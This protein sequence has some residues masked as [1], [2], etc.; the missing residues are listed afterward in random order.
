MPRPLRVLMTTDTLGGVF[1]YS[2]TLCRA[3]RARGVEVMLVTEGARLQ[4]DQKREL[5][6]IAG[7]VVCESSLS[8]EWMDEPWED[9]DRAGGVLL[10][11]ERDFAPDVVHVNGYAH[12]ALPFRAPALIVAHS[13]VPSWWRAV[14]GADA[15]GR[16]AEY[17]RRA[18]AAFRVARLVVA[19]TRSMLRALA[20][21]DAFCGE[22]SIIPNGADP[23]LYGRLPKG[24]FVLAA[25][26]L[27][28]KAKNLALIEAAARSLSW[29]VRVAG[30]AERPDAPSQCEL[31]GRLS[32]EALRELLARAPIFVHPARYEP[33]GLAPLEAGLSGCALVLG[34]I[35]SLRE[36]WGDAATYVRPDD[37]AGLAAATERLISD[38]ELARERGRRARER[39]LAYGVAPMVSAYLNV[40]R[41][42]ART[43]RTRLAGSFS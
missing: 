28:D 34:D 4:N 30:D 25:G 9:V 13:S 35:G 7:L 43:R 3:L 33:F 31:L 18:Q 22:A 2:V 36:I 11:L 32:S 17:R 15:P 38:P 21:H 10:T 12:A 24:E 26:R 1:S 27:W 6:A 8:V 41:E 37:C 19:P 16:Y 29:P 23:A 20:E 42:L 40:Y 5:D 39:A 14:H